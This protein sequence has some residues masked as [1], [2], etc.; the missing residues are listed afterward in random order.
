MHKQV[1]ILSMALLL[2]GCNFMQKEKVPV[3]AP[4]TLNAKAMMY[5]TK[6]ELIGEIF[7]VESQKGV[8]LTAILNSLPPGEHGIH[9]HETGKCEAP[10]FESAG[11]H[12]N[13]T[14]KQHGI[15]N[16]Q[17]PHVGDLPNITA[18]EA[19]EV[20]LNLVT[21]DFTLK[22]GETNSI[23]DEDGTAIV[24]HE[25]ADDYKTDPAGNSGARIACGVIE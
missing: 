3:N 7:L 21:A 23:F 20:Q 25:R 18:D 5:N 15:E 8:E 11:A 12:F 9:L 1:I 16:P 17:G 13:P 6:N 24:I 19:G 2:S 4:E 22:K 10:S 14:N